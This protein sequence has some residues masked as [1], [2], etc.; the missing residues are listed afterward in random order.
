MLMLNANVAFSGCFEDV[1]H[2]LCYMRAEEEF[3]SLHATFGKCLLDV[4]GT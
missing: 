3:I 2:G 1:L 4:T